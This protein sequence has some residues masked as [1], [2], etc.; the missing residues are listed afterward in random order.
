M[1][2][3]ERLTCIVGCPRIVEQLQVRRSHQLFLGN[4]QELPEIHWDE[5]RIMGRQ[6][7]IVEDI[8]RVQRR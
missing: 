8:G 3:S 1:R 2:H 4:T 7:A 6:R 5:T